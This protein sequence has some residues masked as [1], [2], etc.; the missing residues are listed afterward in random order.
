[1][2][3]VEDG[4]DAATVCVSCPLHQGCRLPYGEGDPQAEVLVVLDRPVVRK[5]LLVRMLKAIGLSAYVTT[6]TKC[7]PGLELYREDAKECWGFLEH[8]IQELNPAIILTM[9]R[10]AAQMLGLSSPGRWRGKVFEYRGIQV[11]TTYHPD[12]T[13]HI[14]EA[15]EKVGRDLYALREMIDPT[16]NQEPL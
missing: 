10:P 11:L 9:G 16:L 2:S 12:F 4:A 6:L 14:P 8:Q 7:D 3:G 5:D 1:M 13:A 15:A